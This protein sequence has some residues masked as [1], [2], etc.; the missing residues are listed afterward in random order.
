LDLQRDGKPIDELDSSHWQDFVRELIPL[1]LSQLFFFDGE[2]IQQLAEDTSDQQTLSEAI[3]SLLG[4]DV[5]E[6]LQTDTGIYVSKLPKPGD[7]GTKTHEV[8]ELEREISRVEQTLEGLRSTREQHEQRIT[9]L[10][11]TIGKLETRIVSEGGSFARNREELIEKQG[12]LKANIKRCEESLKNDCAGLLPF[13]LIPTL[14]LQLKE[15]IVLEN[16]ASQRETGKDLLQA[17]R[18]EFLDRLENPELWK[19]LALSGSGK[20]SFQNRLRQAIKA[21]LDIEQGDCVPGVHQLSPSAQQQ[22]LSWIEKATNDLPKSVKA[23]GIELE[24]LHRELDKVESHL[25]KVPPDEILKPLLGELSPASS[26]IGGSQQTGATG[27]GRNQE[28]RAHAGRFKA[29]DP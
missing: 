24:T 27:G 15:Q 10:K 5:I 13:A 28:K 17:A 16:A 1:G 7:N 8:E 19:P 26:T 21:P 29:L 12:N 25:R 11:S 18:T 2:K 22:I 20:R 14:C 9:E 23:L 6:R 3:K 4:L